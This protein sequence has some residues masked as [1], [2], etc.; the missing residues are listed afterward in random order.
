MLIQEITEEDS[1]NRLTHM[2][3][4]RLACAQDAQPYVTPFYF[5]YDS[6][7]FYSFSTVGQRI[8]WM[9][10]NPLV[11]VETD[12]VV[13]SEEWVSIIIFGRYEELPDT[14]QW[15]TARGHAHELLEQKATWW[16]P[17]YVKTI[18]QG[19]ERPLVPVYFRIHIEQITG[20]QGTPDSA[21]ETAA[22]TN[23]NT[24]S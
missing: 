18:I 21:E 6:N 5:A 2:R 16:E 13:S 3:L 1:L 17:G 23:Q 10:V 7:C 4:G 19:A 24:N 12:S 9:R 8:D 11:C 15:E 22:K 14:P 20:H